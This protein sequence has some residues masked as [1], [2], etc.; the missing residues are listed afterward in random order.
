[1]LL[2]LLP[3]LPALVIE[4]VERQPDKVVLRTRVRAA[5][6][7]PVLGAG[8]R[9]ICTPA[10]LRRH[11]RARVVAELRVRRFRCGNTACPAVAFVGP[12]AD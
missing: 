3:Y 6:G 12:T 11:E 5:A 9:P 4:E 1:M 8:A 10:A 2:E 7:L